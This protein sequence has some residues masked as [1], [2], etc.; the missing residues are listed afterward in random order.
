MKYFSK[1]RISGFNIHYDLYTL[2]YFLDCQ[3]KLGIKNVE[4]LAGHQALYVDYN[5]HCDAKAVKKKLDDRGLHCAVLAPE[6]C[7]FQ[8]QFAAKDPLL[9]E[10]SLQKKKNSMRKNKKN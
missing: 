8:Y 2:D 7:C 6:N 5:G 3:A 4:L 10:R 1:E 9:K